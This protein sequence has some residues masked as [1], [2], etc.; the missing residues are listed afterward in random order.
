RAHS[1]MRCGDAATDAL[2]HQGIHQMQTANLDDAL[3]TFTEIIRRRPQFAEA[4]NKGARS[5]Y[6]VGEHRKSL[7]DCDEAYKRNPNHFGA[8][9]GMAQIHVIL[10][11]PE[12][13]LEAYEKAV[14][15]NPNVPDAEENLR[16]LRE[17]VAERKAKT[18]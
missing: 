5:L 14:K 7:R 13:A 3:T 8:L 2:Y 18:V 4:W 10:G 11:Q 9:S 12:H 15:I 17:A 6:M 16:G 1:G